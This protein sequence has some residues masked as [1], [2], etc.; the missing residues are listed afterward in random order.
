MAGTDDGNRVFPL[1]P[2]KEY[3]EACAIDIWA[4]YDPR[5]IPLDDLM[6]FLL[7]QLTVDG[8]LPGVLPTP[9]G[10]GATPST[11]ELE[12]ALRNELQNY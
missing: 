8:V 7:P 9:E 2:L 3:A 6:N 12:A 4:G 1:W 5:E 10:K 11:D